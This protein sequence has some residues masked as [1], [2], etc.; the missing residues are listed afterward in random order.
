M[1][2]VQLA[3]ARARRLLRGTGGCAGSGARS[4]RLC[5]DAAAQAGLNRLRTYFAKNPAPDLHHQTVLLWSASRLEGLMT[6]E[7]KV[8]TIERLRKLERRD[9]G[10]NLPTLGSWKRRDGTPN[11][12]SAP[13]DGYATGLVVYVLRRAGVPT[14]N[15]ALSGASTGLEPTARLR[16]LV[17]PFAQ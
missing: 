6:S 9:G 16:A 5:A 12:Q 3:S 15:P 4:R 8:A 14:T 1:A 10:W 2:Q 11:D 7:Q 13:S 17:H